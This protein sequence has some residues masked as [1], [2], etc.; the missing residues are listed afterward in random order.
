MVS[1]VASM[2][3]W[4]F[5]EYQ[6][7]CKRFKIRAP[8]GAALHVGLDTRIWTAHGSFAERARGGK[9]PCH[10]SAFKDGAAFLAGVALQGVGRLKWSV[11]APALMVAC[12][13]SRLG[14]RPARYEDRKFL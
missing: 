6:L 13:M 8:L 11:P 5:F 2:H 4:R 9:Q 7:Y 10:L 3:D 12:S 1:V 14:C